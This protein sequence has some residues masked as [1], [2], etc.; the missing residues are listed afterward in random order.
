MFGNGTDVYAKFHH[1]LSVQGSMGVLVFHGMTNT[2]LEDDNS[3]LIE[4]AI[5]SFV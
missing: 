5:P 1:N 2:F 3:G 4:G